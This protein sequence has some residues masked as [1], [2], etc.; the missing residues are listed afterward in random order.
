L[1][2]N[3]SVAGTATNGADYVLLPGVLNIPQGS[4]T[5]SLTVTPIDDVLVEGDETVIVTLLESSGYTVGTPSSATVTIASN[6]PDTVSISATDPNAAEPGTDTGTLTVTRI[7]PTTS[8]LTVNYVV[9]GTATNGTDYVA[10]T[11]SHVIPAG[12]ASADITVIPIDDTLMEGNETVIVTLLPG[13]GYVTLGAPSAGTVTIADDDLVTISIS[14]TDANAAEPGTDTGAFTVSRIGP[15]TS[16]L[17]VNYSVTGTATNGTDYVSLPGSL[18]IP[19]GSTSAVLAVTPIDDTLAEGDETVIVTLSASSGYTIG[20][21]SSAIVTIVDNE[22]VISIIATDPNAAERGTD[23]GAFTVSRIGP[24]TSDLVVNYSVTGTATN[25]TDYVSLPGFLAIPAGSA[26]AVLLV[27]PI[28]DTLVEGDETVIVTLSASS[29]YTIGSPSSAIVT[30]VD[31]VTVSISATDPNAAEPG[32]DTGVF[33]VIRMGRVTSDLVVNYSVAGTATNGTDYVSLS[34]SLA[35]PAGSTSAVLTVTAIDDTIVEGDETV[36]V[37]LLESSD[38]TLGALSSATITIADDDLISVSISATDPNAAEPGADTGAF[39][40]TRTG[41]TTS[42]LTVNYSVGGTATNG[43]D[44]RLLPGSVVIPAGSASAIMT[45]TPIDDTLV[46]GNET[47]IVTL[48]TSSLYSIGPASSAIVTIGDDDLPS[49]PLPACII[50]P[51]PGTLSPAQQVTASIMAV[52]PYDRPIQ[53]SLT[54]ASPAPTVLNDPAVQFQ[55]GGRRIDF[56]IPANTMRATFSNGAPGVGFQS[57]TVAGTITLEAILQSGAESTTCSTAINIGLAPP[58]ITQVQ[59]DL[60]PAFAFLITSYSTPRNMSQISF[61]FDTP[62]TNFSC[63]TVSGCSISGSTM[64]FDVR[65]L[66]QSWYESDRTFGSMSTLLVPFTIQGNVVGS[67]SLTMTNSEG[68]SNTVQ[69][70]LP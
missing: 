25:G 24:V 52:S 29:G 15:V 8:G 62:G 14:A 44:Y 39:T 69:I 18:S 23:T 7:G 46:E 66:F 32:T 20:S 33:T 67:V 60:Q 49:P 28:E 6:D 36:I 59:K 51:A 10:L 35:I 27:T 12:S 17:V 63:G 21:P 50:S 40:V 38:Y 61:Q 4:A 9:S 1:T 57:G 30:I 65:S 5:A 58:T 16:D 2:V 45:V 68:S 19:A 56:D 47:V 64:I 43:T 34:G 42:N 55:T 11:G 22:T 70:P 54:I 41:P 31:S 48:S 3:Y 26:S 53:G 13:P 37:T